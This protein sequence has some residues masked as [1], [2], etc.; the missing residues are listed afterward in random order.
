HVPEY[1]TKVYFAD[2]KEVKKENLDGINPL[3]LM[4]NKLSEQWSENDNLRSFARSLSAFAHRSSNTSY[5]FM[6]LSSSLNLFG[7]NEKSMQGAI[8]DRY[9]VDARYLKERRALIR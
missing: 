2:F 5:L 4:D 8:S 1:L 6:E 3:L 9:E 7:D